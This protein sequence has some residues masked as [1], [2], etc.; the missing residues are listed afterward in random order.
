MI[1][2]GVCALD[3]EISEEPKGPETTQGLEGDKGVRTGLQ[4][5]DS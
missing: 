1:Y 4:G 2:W 3:G 5:R